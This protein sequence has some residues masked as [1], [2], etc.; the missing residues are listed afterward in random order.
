MSKDGRPYQREFVEALEEAGLT[1][2]IER[3]NCSE[4]MLGRLR[5]SLDGWGVGATF[6]LYIVTAGSVQQ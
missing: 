6:S 2:R 3:V 5:R 4:D 1:C